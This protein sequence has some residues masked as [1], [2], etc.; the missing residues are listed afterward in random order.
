MGAVGDT[1]VKRG[2]ERPQAEHPELARAGAT[3]GRG[4]KGL[5][6]LLD[7]VSRA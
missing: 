1:A 5:G 6:T 2:Q 4:S 3:S 7:R